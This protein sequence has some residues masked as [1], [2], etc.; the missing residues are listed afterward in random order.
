MKDTGY[1]VVDLAHNHILDSGLSGALNTV[2]TFDKLGM[3]SI[4]VYKNNRD[5]EDILI[6]NVNGSK[7]Q[8]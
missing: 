3:P 7:L 4:G 8:F 6:K 5:K 2:K 1:D